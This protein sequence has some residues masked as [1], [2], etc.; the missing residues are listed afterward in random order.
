MRIHFGN[1]QIC[2]VIHEG[3]VTMLSEKQIEKAVR[4]RYPGRKNRRMIEQIVKEVLEEAE[5]ERCGKCDYCR[6]TKK[7]EKAVYYMEIGV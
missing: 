4:K 7:L 6:S 3:A 1:W 2:L 5:P